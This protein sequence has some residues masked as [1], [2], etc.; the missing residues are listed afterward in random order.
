MSTIGP[1]NEVIEQTRRVL[2]AQPAWL[3]GGVLRDRLLG[4]ETDDLDVIVDGDPEQAAR[5]VARAAGGTAFELSDSH[6]AWRVVDREHR[7]QVDLTRLR[8]GSLE[9]DLALRDFT[10]NAIAEPLAGGS[11]VDPTGGVADL[12]AR[13]LRAVA[14]DAFASD[15]LRS[16]RLARLACELELEPEADT[17]ALAR[18]RAPELERIAAERV[19]AELRRIVACPGVASGLDL[20]DELGLTA[21]VLPELVSLRGVEQNRFHHLDVHDHTRA[22]LDAVVELERDPASAVGS[23]HAAAVAT[24]LDEPLADGVSR[25]VALRF[26][27]LLHDAAKPPTRGVTE[28]GR[29]TFIGHDAEG[30]QLATDVLRRL[31][32]S[33]RLQSHVAD[34][35][36]HHL[37]LGFLVAHQPLGRRDIYRY[38]SACDPVEVDVTL[39]SIADRL[40]TRG[41]NAERAIASHL[42]LARQL[43]GEA[44]AWR[45]RGRP[46]PLVRGDDLARALDLA[47]GPEIGRLL[48]AIA[49][50]RFAGEVTDREQALEHARRLRSQ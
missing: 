39:L 2:G 7:W 11:V 18:E 35:T 25:G 10:V 32:T 13:R 6:G 24:L 26:G 50:A 22:V 44:L 19:F 4:R 3:V 34:L 20:M 48:E 47:P 33:E 43:L 17:I 30:A 36:R 28:A 38:L 27:A 49:E 8:G 12:K 41:D 37:R 21:V 29:V 45:S 9:A 23:E 14:S 40:A 46:A 31:R 42:E 15:P 16:L 5:A 1:V